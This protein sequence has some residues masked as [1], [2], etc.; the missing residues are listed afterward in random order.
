M[1]SQQDGKSIKRMNQPTL[2]YVSVDPK[3]DDPAD[4]IATERSET[5]P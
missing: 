5:S 1:T 2:Y 3:D 4:M